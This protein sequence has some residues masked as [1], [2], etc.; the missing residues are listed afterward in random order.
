MP[1]FVAAHR[2][3]SV[4]LGHE[5]PRHAVSV[6]GHD[7]TA[8]LRELSASAGSIEDALEPML[9]AILETTGATA[10]A[11]CLYDLRQQALRLAAEIGLS[12][13]GCRKLRIIARRG[14]GDSWGIPL[15]GML[16]RRCYLIE[17][18][19][20]N[21]F[22]PPLIP[23]A[24]KIETVACLP[25]YSGDTPLASLVLVTRTPRTLGERELH[26]IEAPVHEIGR[27]I[28]TM[29]QRAVDRE[30]KPPMPASVPTIGVGASGG[31]ASAL[32]A[33]VP[34]ADTAS[35]A[36]EIAR[37]E[38]ERDRVAAELE[39]LR[40]DAQGKTQAHAAALEYLR[41]QLGKA[42]AGAAHEQR[43]REELEV[44]LAAAIQTGRD[45]LR[46][47]LEAA[48]EAESA[49][50]AALA[51]VAELHLLLERERQSA[52]A[53][54]FG[55]SARRLAE[56]D[57]Q[58][59]AQLRTLREPL[60]GDR[61]AEVD[62]LDVRLTALSAEADRLRETQATI[63]SERDRLAADLECMVAARAH[64]DE[65]SNAALQEAST[66]LHDARTQAWAV[67]ARLV[68]TEATL[69][70]SREE[71]KTQIASLTIQLAAL[72]Q[73]LTGVRAEWLDAARINARAAAR[74]RVSDL[75][76]VA[77]DLE[78]CADVIDRIPLTGAEPLR[79]AAARFA[80]IASTIDAEYGRANP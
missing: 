23:D 64:L 47:A 13:E 74:Q 62:V 32:P 71:S 44:H 53:L 36:A 76:I 65:A 19:A 45:E 59:E 18:A 48:R 9:Q 42:E 50:A 25:V 29:R 21:R 37:V 57:S 28:E 30:N 15:H 43:A 31:I 77:R 73:E 4:R 35:L 33:D 8:R 60:A 63:S 20:Q 10:A 27:L 5:G 16:N 26:G 3:P 24:D 55:V 11:L 68:A 7:L 58:L 22:V 56:G 2:V 79:E 70:V 46:K 80:D 51:E 67:A 78:G 40:R 6:I 17:R 38:R 52:R 69:D 1:M 66:Q 72:R 14:E 75:R 39:T 54:A 12:E 61:I 34:S 41:T 49:R